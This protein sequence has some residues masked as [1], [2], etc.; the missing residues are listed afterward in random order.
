MKQWWIACGFATA[1][2]GATAVCMAEEPAAQFLDKLRQAGYFDAAI[3]YLD[4]M[5]ELRAAGYTFRSGLSAD[6]E[7]YRI[8]FTAAPVP[9]PASMALMLAGLGALGWLTSRRR[10]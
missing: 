8:S 9:E 10:V 7:L 3:D 6:T 5:Q 1:I 4:L 2:F